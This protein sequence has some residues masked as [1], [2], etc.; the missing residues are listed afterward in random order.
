MPMQT[1]GLEQLQIAVKIGIDGEACY[2]KS[3][4]TVG[5]K[6]RQGSEGRTK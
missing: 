2:V 6:T 3:P 4:P 5:R 1:N